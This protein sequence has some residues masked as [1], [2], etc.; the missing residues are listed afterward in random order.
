M[1][2]GN[3]WN[4]YFSIYMKHW[5]K[6]INRKCL[7]LFLSHW[8]N[9]QRLIGYKTVFILLYLETSILQVKKKKKQ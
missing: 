7:H 3:K 4:V 2:T 5:G 1:K 8:F 6:G 9:Q